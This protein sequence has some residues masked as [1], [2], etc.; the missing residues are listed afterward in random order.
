MIN[1]KSG[2][3]IFTEG[4]GF[5][6]SLIQFFTE[7]KIS[8]AGLVYKCPITEELYIWE[9]GDITSYSLPIITRNDA[10]LN[11]AHLIPLKNKF[12]KEY[13]QNIYVKRLIDENNIFDQLSYDLFVAMNLGKPYLSNLVSLWTQRGINITLIDIGFMQDNTEFADSF[14]HE[15]WMCSQVIY[16]FL[17]F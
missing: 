8:H 2:D 6:S 3:I 11:A 10:P 17:F 13:T 7:S 15:E 16:I 12:C 1:V 9:I 14:D 4:L 5:N